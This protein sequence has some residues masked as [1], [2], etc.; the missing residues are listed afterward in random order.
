MMEAKE[1]LKKMEQEL[2]GN[3]GALNKFDDFKVAFWEYLGSGKPT[4]GLIFENNKWYFP[5]DS[6][7]AIAADNL[8]S[9]D[10]TAEEFAENLAKEI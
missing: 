9:E 5:E 4:D 10:V 2:E 8:L 3:I 7:P 6:Y 1:F